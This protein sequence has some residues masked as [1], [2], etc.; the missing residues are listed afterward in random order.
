MLDISGY[1]NGEKI[2]RHPM[3]KILRHQLKR[4]FPVY[5]DFLFDT[6]PDDRAT[7][8]AS[9]FLDASKFIPKNRFPQQFKEFLMSI[10]HRVIKAIVSGEKT[11]NFAIVNYVHTK[12]KK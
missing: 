6:L 11:F 9:L 2:V 4:T 10:A 12:H 5:F 3:E 1:K 8:N 7:A